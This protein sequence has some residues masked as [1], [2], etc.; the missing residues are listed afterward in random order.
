MTVLKSTIDSRSPEFAA[1]RAAMQ[2]VVDDLRA[3]VEK[4]KL[5]GGEAARAKHT[6]RGKMLPRERVRALLDPGSPS[7]HRDGAANPD[8][9][10]PVQVE[11]PIAGLTCTTCV[12]TVERSLEEVSG[13]EQVKVNFSLG[14]AKF[15]KK[16]E[17]L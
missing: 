8:L 17:I 16:I 13:V 5:G 6:A 2:A 7:G 10:G 12:T 1:N 9:A 3:Q 15:A 4:V 14:K 11:L